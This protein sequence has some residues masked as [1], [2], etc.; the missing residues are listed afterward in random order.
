MSAAPVLEVDDLHVSFATRAG[1]VQAVR[2]VSLTLHAGE[3]LA[4][5]GESGSGKSVTARA[6]TGLLPANGRVDAGSVRYRGQDLVRADERALRRVR[7]NGIAM[8]FQDPMTC[9]DPTMTI[10]AQVAEPLRVHTSLSRR[11]ARDAAVRLLE[12][13]GIPEPA[14][15]ARQYPHQFS[16]GQRQRI[17]IAIALV[18]GP[19][20]VL[21]DE[22]TTALD[23]RVQA[24][25]LDLLGELRRDT[26]T[27]VVLVTHDLGVVAS[28]ADRVAVMYAG[29]IVEIGTARE[30]FGHPQHPYTWGLL[31]SLP[32]ADQPDG[33][34]L[35]IPGSPPDMIDPPTGD[36]FWPRN[37]YAVRIDTEQA[38]PFFDVSPTHRAATWLLAPGAPAVEPPP[39]V[40]QRWAR[41]AASADLP[42]GRP[43]EPVE[44][45]GGR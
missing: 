31:G 11:A 20:V 37:P 21:A 6:V 38:P 2:G 23:V 41:H 29:R 44:P 24:Q 5:V 45:G 35:A 39:A 10:G 8:V 34:L 42:A 32:T 22:P 36:A 27:A 16:G 28:V 33:R 1:R 17:A 14:V 3:V 19:D 7:G 13:V 25:V 12:R 26:G 43:T 18:C 30:V 40:A 9:L 15:R 4:V